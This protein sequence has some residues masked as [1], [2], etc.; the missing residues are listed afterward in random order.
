MGPLDFSDRNHEL[1]H[2]DRS[3][4]LHAIVA[5]HK[6]ATEYG[7]TRNNGLGTLCNPALRSIRRNSVVQTSSTLRNDIYGRR[8]T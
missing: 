1:V 3:S 8:N 2:R 6:I 7:L 4:G 5:I